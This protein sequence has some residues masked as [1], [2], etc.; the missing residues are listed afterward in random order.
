[1]YYTIKIG[2]SL[3]PNAIIYLSLFLL[4]AKLNYNDNMCVLYKK[5]QLQSLIALL[6]GV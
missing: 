4:I 2:A 6:S 1:M 5:K 3:A